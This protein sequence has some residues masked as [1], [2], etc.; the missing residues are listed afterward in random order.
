M[1]GTCDGMKFELKKLDYWVM[2][3]KPQAFIVTLMRTKRD[4][5]YSWV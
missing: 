3:S 2:V 1:N 5:V 4:D